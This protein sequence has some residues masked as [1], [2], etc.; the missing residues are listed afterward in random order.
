MAGEPP[1]ARAPL[2]AERS[3]TACRDPD[4]RQALV[5]AGAFM[6]HLGEF[7]ARQAQ[8]TGEHRS[9]CCPTAR[10]RVVGDTGIFILHKQR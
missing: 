7:P 3:G 2:P 5:R 4:V 9:S 6:P 1:T 10:Y 8:D